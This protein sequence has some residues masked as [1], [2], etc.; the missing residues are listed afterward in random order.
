MLRRIIKIEI[1]LASIIV[2]LFTAVY[3]QAHAYTENLRKQTQYYQ[4]NAFYA[5]E[6]L[7]TKFPKKHRDEQ[8]RDEFYAERLKSALEK[9]DE[10]R[11]RIPRQTAVNTKNMYDKLIV[12]DLKEMRIHTYKKGIHIESSPILSKGKKGSRWETPSGLYQIATKEKNHFSSIGSVNMPYS[13]QFFGNFFIHGWPTHRDGSPVPRGYSG[14]CIRLDTDDANKIFKFAK[15]GTKVLIVNS[16]PS[17]H[18]KKLTMS[19]LRSPLVTADAYIIADIHTGE[20]Y[21]QK[22]IDKVRPIASVTKLITALVAN[23]VIRYNAQVPIIAGNPISP[24]DYRGIH[25]GTKIKAMDTVYPLLMESNNAVAHALA[26]HYGYNN[27]ITKMRQMTEAMHMQNT[28]IEDPSGISPRNK[29]TV[30][31]LFRLAQY[32]YYNSQ[33]VL[34]VTRQKAHV[35][36]GHGY[37]YKV[38]NHNHFAD[39]KN[40]IGGKTGYTP[41][42]KQTMLSIFDTEIS[43]EKYTVAVIILGSSKRKKDVSILYNWFIKNAYINNTKEQSD[44]MNINHKIQ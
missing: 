15:R 28:T 16:A 7:R 24:N 9:Q 19:N 40:F 21:A 32:I 37:H 6:V 34:N 26:H 20:I 30:R 25:K 39:N 22:N 12:A 13:M 44:V 33:F 42:A 14:G 29:S 5:E 31:D 36:H 18:K 23:A 4:A 3:V 10:K 8:S 2:L 27:F 41:Q 43:G 38:I 35:V 17:N 11:E 1:I